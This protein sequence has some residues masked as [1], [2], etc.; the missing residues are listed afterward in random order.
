MD[1]DIPAGEPVSPTHDSSK[2]YAQ[3]Q[4]EAL[5]AS[6]KETWSDLKEAIRVSQ[7]RVSSRENTKRRDPV[8]AAGDLAYLNTRHL[9]RGRPTLKLDYRWTGPYRVEAVHGGSAKLSLPAGSK[10]HATVNLSYL[11]RFDNNPLPGQATGAESLD[12]VIAGMDPSED[13][14]DVTRNLDP[15]INRQYRGGRLQ[16]W[17]SWRGWPDDPTWYNCN[18]HS[19][20]RVDRMPIDFHEYICV[21]T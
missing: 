11:R 7:A 15:R 21:D 4:A 8:L 3:S 12:P 19:S 17:V 16:F 5:A 10:I 13:E 14:F 6:L 2:H 1:F 20:Y 18:D 9:S